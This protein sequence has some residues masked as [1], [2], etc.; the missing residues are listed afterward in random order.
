MTFECDE[1]P[2]ART[3]K[4]VV[5]GGRDTSGMTPA[6]IDAYVRSQ[7]AAGDGPTRCTPTPSPRW[8]PI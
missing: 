5:V 7:L 2:S 8:P 1:P 3:D 4:T 6:A